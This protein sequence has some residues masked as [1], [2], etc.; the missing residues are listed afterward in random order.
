M[1]T[2][3]TSALLTRLREVLEDGY[4]SLRTIAAATYGGNLPEDFTG[5]GDSVR[6]LGQP[7]VECLITK[8]TR[9][10]SSPILKSNVALY[11]LDVRVRIVRRMSADLA[12]SE[13]ARDAV[14]A[15]ASTDAD[16]I[17]QALSWPGNLTTTQAGAS[18]GVVSGMLSHRESSTTVS[19]VVEDGAS[20]VETLHLFTGTIQSA[21][22]VS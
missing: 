11:E 12:V 4:G 9:S 19:G 7:Q 10:P 15:A 5:Q 22:P 21:P 17:T 6:S 2:I 1:T 16:V 13:T 3:A 8:I 14:K 20:I 18:T